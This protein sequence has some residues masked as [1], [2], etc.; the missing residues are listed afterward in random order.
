MSTNWEFI[1]SAT[2]KTQ[3]GWS[4]TLNP[5]QPTSFATFQS[6][7][8]QWRAVAIQPVSQ[9]ALQPEEVYVRD[10]DLIVRFA[11]TPDDEFSFALNWRTLPTTGNLECGV[12]L[13]ASIQ[14][15]RLDTSPELE[16]R[17]DGGNG[18]WSILKH[19]ELTESSDGSSPEVAAPAAAWVLEHQDNLGRP[20]TGIWLIEP[21]DQRH[22]HP[23]SRQDERLQ[24]VRLFDHF[25]EKGVIR[26]ARMQFWTAACKLSRDE[27]RAAYQAFANRPLPLTA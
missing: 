4:L 9:H 24:R 7:T 13:W 20:C 3:H 12:E 18:N 5:T 2:S 26:R 11:Q 22:A 8:G 1:Q 27:I 14:T 25:M 19:C 17:S 6:E 10:R 15:Q 21:T 23:L 16:L